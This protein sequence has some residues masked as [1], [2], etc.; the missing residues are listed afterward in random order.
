MKVYDL[1]T[2]DTTGC[3]T[4]AL[5]LEAFDTLS[6]EIWDYDFGASDDFLGCC[7]VDGLM[8]LEAVEAAGEA[9]P[10]VRFTLADMVEADPSGR[11]KSNIDPQGILQIEL[12]KEVGSKT[13]IVVEVDRAHQ[14]REPL[15]GQGS[16]AV[17]SPALSR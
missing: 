8:L 11:L 5:C 14:V 15:H 9:G 17:E 2:G 7:T 6:C 4:L 12:G 16:R 3:V 10:G 1:A 13:N